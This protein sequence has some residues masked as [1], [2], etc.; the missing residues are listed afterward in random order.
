MFFPLE[1]LLRPAPRPLSPTQLEEAGSHLLGDWEGER[2]L[3]ER[4]DFGYITSSDD[5]FARDDLDR[6][7]GSPPPPAPR[8]LLWSGP[9]GRPQELMRALPSW[10]KLRDFFVPELLFRSPHVDSESSQLLLR[11][12]GRAAAALSATPASQAEAEEVVGAPGLLEAGEPAALTQ[13]GL[14]FFPREAE[15]W[16]SFFLVGTHGDRSPSPVMDPDSFVERMTVA[17]LRELPLSGTFLSLS[18][19]CVLNQLRPYLEGGPAHLLWDDLSSRAGASVLALR[20]AASAAGVRGLAV[21]LWP[22]GPAQITLQAR[23]Y[24]HVAGRRADEGMRAGGLIR[25]WNEARRDL[26]YVVSELDD[27][28]HVVSLAHPFFWAGSVLT[29]GLF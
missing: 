5:L 13:V 23:V 19:G 16:N 17:Q 11:I 29:P 1:M 24:E 12:M 20:L 22:V 3:L 21:S 15:P 7:A 14:P 18:S 9:H 6:P 25:A 8:A 26:R 2:V 4:Y 10:E 28:H 27:P